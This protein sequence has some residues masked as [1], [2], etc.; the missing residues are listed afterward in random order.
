MS[1]EE[2]LK[3][4][5][6]KYIDAI[7]KSDT[8]KVKKLRDNLVALIDNMKDDLHLINHLRI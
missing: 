1:K 3:E 5:V 7:D 8:D 4:L 2:L 6:N